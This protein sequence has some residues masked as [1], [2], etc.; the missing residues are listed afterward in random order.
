MNAITHKSPVLLAF[1]IILLEVLIEFVYLVVGGLVQLVGEQLNHEVRFISPLTQLLLLP[2]QIGVLVFMLMRWSSE[3]YEIRDEELIVRHGVLK[4]TELA[5]PFRN[6][7]SVIVR[8]SVIERLVGAGTVSIFVPTL[9]KDLIF[10]EVPNP[11][12]FAESIKK[13]IPKADSNS[14]FILKR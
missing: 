6:M 7:Q 8:Q 9:G 12:E 13:A 1:K 2:V 3:T 11:K 5:Y 4:K 14:Q 10:S